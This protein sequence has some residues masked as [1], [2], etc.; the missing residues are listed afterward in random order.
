MLA[1]PPGP[2]WRVRLL[3][4]AFPLSRV[5]YLLKPEGIMTS[6]TGYGISLVD[7]FAA[8]YQSLLPDPPVQLAETGAL[9]CIRTSSI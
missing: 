8:S 4:L 5:G 7:Q 9:L 1:S 2:D 3:H 6:V